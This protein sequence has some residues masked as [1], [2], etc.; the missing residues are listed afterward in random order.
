MDPSK[1]LWESIGF[2]F[3]YCFLLFQK[4]VSIVVGKSG[5][6]GAK[7][8]AFKNATG[9]IADKK[10]QSIVTIVAIAIDIVLAV[11]IFWFHSWMAIGS[12]DVL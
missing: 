9:I 8:V 4:G 2:S 10:D 6:D 5:Q 11:V 12:S 7:I 1:L 3:S